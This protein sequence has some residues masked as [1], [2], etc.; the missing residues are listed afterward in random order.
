MGQVSSSSINSQVQHAPAGEVIPQTYN[1]KA[2]VASIM[3]TESYTPPEA[4]RTHNRSPSMQSDISMDYPLEFKPTTRRPHDLRSSPLPDS[5]E[6][7]REEI[8]RETINESPELESLQSN[9]VKPIDDV[10]VPEPPVS[11]SVSESA[12]ALAPPSAYEPPVSELNGGEADVSTPPPPP[13]PSGQ[14]V[15]N[16]SNPYAPKSSSSKTQRLSK[17]GPPG[18]K[19]TSRYTVPS[20]GSVPVEDNSP[21]SGSADM[22]SYGGYSQAPPTGSS[23][24]PLNTAEEKEQV[25]DV[26]V[27]KA[28]EPAPVQNYSNASKYAPPASNYNATKMVPNID[29]SFDND[30]SLEEEVCDIQTPKP[31]KLFLNSGSPN[32]GNNLANPYQGGANALDSNFG[33]PIPGSPDYTTRANSVVGGPTGLFSSRLSQSHQSALY[34]QYEVN[35]DTVRDYVPVVEEEEEDE[36]EED[37]KA[38]QEAAKKE[39]QEKKAREEAAKA[40]VRAD[41]AAAKRD[42]NQG[43]WFAWLGPKDDGK[44]KATRANLGEKNVF[45]FD[46]THKRWLDSTKP[47]D[48]QLAAAAPPPPPSMKKKPVPLGG[49]SRPSGAAPGAPPSAGGPP[50][51]APTA[52]ASGAPTPLGSASNDGPTAPSG[53]AGRAPQKAKP[54]LA[55]AGLDELLSLGGSAPGGGNARKAKRGARRGYVNVMDQN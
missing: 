21:L 24:E 10:P 23:L 48:E 54:S 28:P 37:V 43:K 33:F 51:G 31:S 8:Y 39:E 53:P 12:S 4:F 14:K 40:R 45:Y 46:E 2:S 30:H 55:T 22:F 41:A 11:E 35:D 3:S 7:K 18:G 49:P 17:Y 1:R 52:S 5:P 19:T 15:P 34:Q 13:P 9:Q 25:D 20:A 47:I 50:S 29:D 16:K 36:D 6:K 27:K 44:P 42:P 26:P 32:T 38:K